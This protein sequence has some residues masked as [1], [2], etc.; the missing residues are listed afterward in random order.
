MLATAEMLAFVLLLV[1][2]ATADAV[3]PHPTLTRRA[4]VVHTGHEPAKTWHCTHQARGSGR[5]R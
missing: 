1:I 3:I 2:V 5:R 4:F